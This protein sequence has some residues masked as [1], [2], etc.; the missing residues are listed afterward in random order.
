MGEDLGVGADAEVAGGSPSE[1]DV[2]V[3][4]QVER[5]ALLPDLVVEALA[6]RA[7]GQPHRGLRIGVRRPREQ[8]QQGRGDDAQ[9]G[10]DAPIPRSRS[11][12]GRPWY[13]AR[14]AFRG[15]VRAA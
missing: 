12:H 10:G 4:P 3:Q 13:Q 9:A 6:R 8:R 11:P 7:D 1:E 15:T 5:G 2:P 14:G